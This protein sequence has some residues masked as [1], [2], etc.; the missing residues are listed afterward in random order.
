MQNGI[1]TLSMLAEL[2]V[3]TVSP[4]PRVCPAPASVARSSSLRPGPSSKLNMESRQPAATS[5][6]APR[7]NNCLQCNL[8]YT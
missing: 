8:C 3:G 6:C 5:A 7:H 4:T 2:T 1:I